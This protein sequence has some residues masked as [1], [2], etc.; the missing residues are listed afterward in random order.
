[1]WAK[2]GRN[3]TPQRIGQENARRHSHVF[4][5]SEPTAWPFND[6]TPNW[7]I[8]V[9]II[10]MYKL[11]MC[12]D[13][14]QRRY[15]Y[16]NISKI[17]AYIYIYISSSKSRFVQDYVGYSSQDPSSAVYEKEKT[18][19]G[20][21]MLKFK[22]WHQTVNS[23]TKECT[24]LNIPK[25]C[26]NSNTSTWIIFKG[27]GLLSTWWAVTL[28]HQSCALCFVIWKFSKSYK[29]YEW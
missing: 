3:V 28:P 21:D 2:H 5:C 23:N 8:T 27:H 22:V 25:E 10:C 6:A 9:H 18:K 1:M 24:N 16:I 4:F 26:I 20:W 29:F 14:K 12:Y 13:E 17:C 15:T 7:I 19:L 11:Y